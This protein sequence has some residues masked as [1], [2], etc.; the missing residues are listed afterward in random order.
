VPAPNPRN[1]IAPRRRRLGGAVDWTVILAIAAM[2]GLFLIGH[3]PPGRSI[4]DVEE[5]SLEGD[6]EIFRGHQRRANPSPRRSAGKRGCGASIA[7]SWSI[8]FWPLQPA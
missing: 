2:A 8:A 7:M 1:E 3:G 6:A 5:G 4:S